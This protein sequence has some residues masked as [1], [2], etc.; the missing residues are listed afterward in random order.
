MGDTSWVQ[1]LVGRLAPDR[2]DGAA[3]EVE[4]SRRSLDETEHLVATANDVAA[5]LHSHAETNR[6]SRR[7]EIHLAGRLY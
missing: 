2:P 4:R 6:F 7:I 5:R 1:R 3:D